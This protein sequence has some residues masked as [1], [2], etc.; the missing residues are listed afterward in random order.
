M[1]LTWSNS[2]ALWHLQVQ[3]RDSK[4]GEWDEQRQLIEKQ[5]RSQA[6]VESTSSS[7][8][9]CPK[10]HHQPHGQP[11]HTHHSKLSRVPHLNNPHRMSYYC[12]FSTLWLPI[13]DLLC[14][15]PP[16]H[17]HPLHKFDLS[18]DD[19]T[20]CQLDGELLAVPLLVEEKSNDTS[21]TGIPIPSPSLDFNDNEDIPTELSDSSETHDEGQCKGQMTSCVNQRSMSKEQVCWLT[22]SVLLHGCRCT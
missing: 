9:G 13:K 18:T 2:V 5:C 16:P 6:W 1:G 17:P 8:E 4:W 10:Q 7:Q 20:D 15:C 12:G 19:F 22:I 3:W 21:G 14:C 11:W